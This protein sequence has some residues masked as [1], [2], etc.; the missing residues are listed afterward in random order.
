[1]LAQSAVSTVEILQ[2]LQ[3]GFNVQSAC[4]T[5]NTNLKAQ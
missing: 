5:E 3:I 1:M 4:N 2:I